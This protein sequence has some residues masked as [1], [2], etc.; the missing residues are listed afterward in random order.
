MSPIKPQFPNPTVQDLQRD[1]D[2]LG[3]VIRNSTMAD[4]T[5]DVGVVARK[6]DERN[7]P[8]MDR[9]FGAITDAY[10]R[11]EMRDVR[12]GCS[13]RTEPRRVTVDPSELDS[14]EVQSVLQAIIAAKSKVAAVDT[15][16][17]GKVS[18]AEK[19]AMGDANSLVEELAGSAVY[20]SLASYRSELRSW[21]EELGRV[22][23][24]VTDRKAFDT[25]LGYAAKEQAETPRGA[26]AILWSYR[27]LATRGSGPDIW[28]VQDRLHDAE[29][30]WLR[31]IPFFGKMLAQGKGHL[32]DDEIKS[33]LRT[34]DLEALISE[35]K[36]TINVRIGG[37][38]EALYLEGKDLPGADQFDD[39]DFKK[40]RTRC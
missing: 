22:Y 12:I 16:H 40:S 27:E 14:T 28:A 5:L 25:Q 24:S 29:T 32:N 6:I 1:L 11:T 38:Y 13:L 34:G 18:K 7:D 9:G 39:P 4:G 15:N 17:D 23:S 35:K 8:G 37:S 33:H 21:N 30:S 26:E 10:Q 3:D 36:Q 31:F 19:A 2:N 20:G